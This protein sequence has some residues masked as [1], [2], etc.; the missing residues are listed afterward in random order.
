MFVPA[1]FIPPKL[2]KET[3]IARKLSARDVYL[4]YIAVMAS[5][6]IIHTIRGGK[7]PTSELTIEE[8][9]IDLCWHQREFEFKTS[10]AY[11]IMNN[12]ESKCLGCL[13]FYPPQAGMSNA[14]SQADSDVS[15]SWWITQEMYDHGFYDVLSQDI[16]EWVRS[17]WPFKKVFWANKTLPTG[18]S[19]STA[20]L[21]RS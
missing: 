7:W 2:E 12:D 4:D 20:V 18:F 3:Y 6:D 5:I 9:L 10:F 11:T 16:K 14:A 15:I 17:S 1:N 21:P 8:D 19:N 13:Y